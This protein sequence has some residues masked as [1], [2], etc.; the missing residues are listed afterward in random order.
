MPKNEKLKKQFHKT[1]NKK[2]WKNSKILRK[3]DS[4]PPPPPPAPQKTTEK[5]ILTI[6]N[7]IPKT[8]KKLILNQKKGGGFPRKT[9][10]K[11][12]QPE[13]NNRNGNKES[14]KK[15]LQ[16]VFNV[17]FSMRFSTCQ[18]VLSSLDYFNFYSTTEIT[19]VRC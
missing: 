10:K 6:R 13:K 18:Y 9:R 14:F 11:V 7:K 4:Y 12:R 19:S 5:Y 17:D 16:L 15:V 8:E 2:I 1:K 3:T